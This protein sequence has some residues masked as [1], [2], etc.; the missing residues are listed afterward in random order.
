MISDSPYQVGD[1]IYKPLG[2]ILAGLVAG[3]AMLGFFSLAGPL[4]PF[5]TEEMLTTLGEQ[6]LSWTSLSTQG[7]MIGG[8][9]IFELVTALGGLLYGVSQRSIPND[10]LLIVGASF[11]ILSWIVENLIGLLLNPELRMMMRSWGWL[12]ANII[13]GFLLALIAVI[14]KS[15]SARHKVVKPRH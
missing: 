12:I 10:A 8:L 2:A 13:F 11:G 15:T 5:T 9:V 6:F 4:L 1:E 14:I 3:F 7:L